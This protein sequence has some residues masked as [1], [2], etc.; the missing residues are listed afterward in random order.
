MG[1]EEM[2][3]SQGTPSGVRE[4]EEEVSRRVDEALK[5]VMEQLE[6]TGWE[7]TGTGSL[8]KAGEEGM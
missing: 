2:W 8:E 4:M 5:Q 1:T 7:E 3:K 6:K